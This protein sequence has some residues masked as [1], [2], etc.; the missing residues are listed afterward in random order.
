MNTTTTPFRLLSLGDIA[1][2]LGESK[3]RVAYIIDSRGIKPAGRAGIVRVFGEDAVDRIRTELR[4]IDQRKAGEPQAT[5][6]PT[7]GPAT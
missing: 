3:A 4:R 1:Q 7:D 2:L 6:R 5:P